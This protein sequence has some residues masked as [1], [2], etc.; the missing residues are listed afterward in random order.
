LARSSS[1]SGVHGPL[2]SPT[3]LQHGVVVVDLPAVTVADPDPP[4]AFADGDDDDDGFLMSFAS[5]SLS[6]SLKSLSPDKM[7]RLSVYMM[8]MI[9]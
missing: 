9:G 4:P 1:S 7:S 2:F 8:T 6:I 3:L 5:L